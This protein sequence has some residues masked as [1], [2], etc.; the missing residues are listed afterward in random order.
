MRNL[1]RK[2]FKSDIDRIIKLTDESILIF[3]CHI[4]LMIF[5][6]KMNRGV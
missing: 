6:S 4:D 2:E 3:L 5:F 1:G